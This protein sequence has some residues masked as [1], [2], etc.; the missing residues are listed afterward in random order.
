MQ[1]VWTTGQKDRPLNNDKAK[2]NKAKIAILQE[3]HSDGKN[4]KA[5][6]QKSGMERYTILRHIVIAEET[7][8]GLI[9]IPISKRKR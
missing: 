8:F 7:Q 1:G 6:E 9:R 5:W 4:I 3:I 2:H